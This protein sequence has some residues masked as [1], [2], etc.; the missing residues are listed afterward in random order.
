MEMG[1]VNHLFLKIHPPVYSNSAGLEFPT[2]KIFYEFHCLFTICGAFQQHYSHI[3]LPLCFSLLTFLPVYVR[4][5]NPRPPGCE[6]T[7]FTT[8]TMGPSPFVL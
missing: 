4:E 1:F 6:S 8:K 2:N 3:G 7:V 5:L